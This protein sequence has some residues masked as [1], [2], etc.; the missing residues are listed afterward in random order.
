MKNETTAT[1][2]SSGRQ[3]YMVDVNIN[4]VRGVFKKD[5]PALNVIGGI[6]LINERDEES[7]VIKHWLEFAKAN[8]YGRVIFTSLTSSVKDTETKYHD[9]HTRFLRTGITVADD[10]VIGWGDHGSIR[11]DMM[12]WL[13]H[14]FDRKA[15]DPYCTGVDSLLMPVPV[16]DIDK[17]TV[18]IDYPIKKFKDPNYDPSND[19]NQDLI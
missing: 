10:V 1:W 11:H 16:E 15:I 12:D 6:P 9:M 18:L 7:E 19:D 5:L 4:L 14:Q 8:G 13:L 2:S 3:L 17:D